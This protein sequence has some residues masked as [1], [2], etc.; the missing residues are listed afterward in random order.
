MPF[1]LSFSNVC[2]RPEFM[3][4][5]S[6]NSV[7]C[8]CGA[9]WSSRWLMMQLTNAQHPC[10]LMF[11]SEA[12]ILNILCDCQFFSVLDE[13]YAWCS[14]WCSKCILKVWNVMFHFQNITLT[15]IFRWRGYF[16]Y[17]YKNFFLL[18]ECKNSKNRSNFSDV[19]T[20]M[21]CHLFIVH[22][23]CPIHTIHFL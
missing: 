2:M 16:S 18:K 19:M 7:Y 11:V 13:L 21:Y 3:T 5:M 15:T 17:M 6:C 14:K 1:G 10:V 8:M 4:S 20:Q 23:V 12:D 9:T 22:S